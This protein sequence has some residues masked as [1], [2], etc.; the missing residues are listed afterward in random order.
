LEDASRLATDLLGLTRR[1]SAETWSEVIRSML[2][3]TAQIRGEAHPN[4]E[5]DLPEMEHTVRSA[6]SSRSVQVALGLAWFYAKTGRV[7]QAR[8]TLAKI[9]PSELAR[10]PVRYG[11]LGLLCSL[12]ESMRKLG[13]PPERLAELYAQLGPYE[14]LNAV[15][16]NFAY[17][18]AVGHWL[19][20]LAR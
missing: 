7:E 12:A 2:V 18:G 6:A 3:T 4:P 15:L 16:P 9:R 11:D 17:L 14:S 19:G 5:L 20:M 8:A 1:V 10:M 13:E